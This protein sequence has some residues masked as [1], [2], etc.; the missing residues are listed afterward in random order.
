ME[1]DLDHLLMMAGHDVDLADE[2][3]SIFETQADIWH[4]QLN[5]AVPQ[6]EWADAAH[7][8][9]GAA[10]SLGAIELATVCSEAEGQGRQPELLG[11]VET[12][13]LLSEVRE[14]LAK[15]LDACARARHQLSR[16]GLRVASKDLNS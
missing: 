4:Q 9:K 15:T 8:L 14:V 1:L 13:L 11:Q 2:V 7:A 5:T 12:A 6:S 16:P 10:L 3:V